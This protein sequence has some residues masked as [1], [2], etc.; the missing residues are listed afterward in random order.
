MTAAA[1]LWPAGAAI[2]PTS[3]GTVSTTTINSAACFQGAL[4]ATIDSLQEL[5]VTTNNGD[6]DKG[7]SS[8]AQVSLATKSGTNNFHGSACE[9]NQSL[10]TACHPGCATLPGQSGPTPYNLFH[11]QFSLWGWRTA[12]NGSY[13]ALNLTLRHAFSSAAQFDVNYTYL[14]S[15][16]IG[17][18]AERI[19]LFDV[20]GSDVGGFS[21]QVINAWEPNQLRAVSD[22]DMKHQINSNWIVE[23]PVGRGSAWD[24]E[25]DGWW[26]PARRL[27]PFGSFPL[28]QRIALQ[29]FRHR[30]GRRTMT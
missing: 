12:D 9:Y 11:P 8:G 13:N 2:K 3:P 14:K 23:L 4:R 6:A 10:D 7:R 16:D 30:A 15:I 17:S 19:N 22:F 25:W 24:Q 28:E 20:S 26:M 27:E 21:S 1:A 5:R 18:N 29:H